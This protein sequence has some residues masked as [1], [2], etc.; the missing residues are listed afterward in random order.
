MTGTFEPVERRGRQQRWRSFS[1]T[2]WGVIL[3]VNDVLVWQG[4]D[5]AGKD[6]TRG[7]VNIA[8]YTA[9]ERANHHARSLI[10]TANIQ[11]HPLSP[12]SL[13]SPRR[14][15]LPGTPARSF[16]RNNIGSQRSHSYRQVSNSTPN[17][18][19]P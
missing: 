15:S 9:S 14:G 2:G 6:P 18:K 19:L 16:K 17:P 8:Q 11:V 4:Y 13:V 3:S 10:R 12:T 5:G 7:T 1:P